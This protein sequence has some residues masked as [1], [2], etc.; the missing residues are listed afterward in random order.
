[1]KDPKKLSQL[2]ELH[3]E[4]K[5]KAHPLLDQEDEL[6]MALDSTLPPRRDIFP[7][8]RPKLTR[9]FYNTLFVLFLILVIGLTVW[10]AKMR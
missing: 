3:L 10:G 5:G 7:S 8:K 2:I 6:I 9:L 1:M 4:L